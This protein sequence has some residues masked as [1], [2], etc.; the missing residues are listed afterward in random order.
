MTYGRAKSSTE[1]S[2]DFEHLRPH[3]REAADFLI[4]SPRA[5]LV[6]SRVWAVRS[7]RHHPTIQH[8]SMCQKATCIKCS[9]SSVS[10][11]GTGRAT[12]IECT[13]K[14]SWWGCGNHVP[15]VLD[16]VP[17]ARRC[18]CEPAITREGKT[19]PHMAHDPG[20]FIRNLADGILWTRGR[21]AGYSPE[22]VVEVDRELK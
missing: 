14:Q 3:L 4:L 1:L 17:A 13:E 9:T 16:R 11:D 7:S 12:N 6:M 19:Y 15:I 22:G 10:Q 2:P 8:S 21:R 5:Y 18:S 20:W